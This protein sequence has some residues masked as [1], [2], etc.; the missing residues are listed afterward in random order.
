MKKNT[1]CV[2]AGGYQDPNTSGLSTPIFTSSA[3]NYLD[4]P[5]QPYPRYFN[6]P[7]QEA[8]AAKLAAL[9]GA[10][11]A[12]VFSSG[13]AAIST[14]LLSLLKSGDHI[15][16]Q[17]ELYG[18]TFNLVAKE[19]SRQN[20]DYTL[21]AT[22]ADAVI[23]AINKNTRVIYLES[24]TNPLLTIV[25]IRRITGVAI[26]KG[27]TTVIDNTFASPINQNPLNLGVDIVLHSGTKYLAGHS[28]LCCGVVAS[29][30]SY[31]TQLHQT[32]VNFGGSMDSNSCSLLER[33]LKTLS[34][35]VERQCSNALSLAKYLETLSGVSKVFYPGLESSPYHSIAKSQM[36]GFGGML[37]FELAADIS[38]EIFLKKLK[39][40][41]PALSLG[42]IESTICSPAA[43][44]HLKMSQDQ[45][46]AIGITDA[47]LRLSVGIEDIEDL[48]QD[49]AQALN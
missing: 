16:L 43:T 27:I 7:N 14:T 19:F 25:D 45:R 32:A 10:E 15:V 41:S 48:Q 2:H 12:M 8:V 28:D 29:N 35:R 17:N 13:M 49:I 44:S 9:E 47:I 34:L 4:N 36:H 38:P 3:Y 46:E 37:A 40:I 31:I 21:T 42:G 39:L 30:Q 11:A 6:T 26:K 33:S 22:H 18:G 24:P 23:E 20:I 1:L 5:K